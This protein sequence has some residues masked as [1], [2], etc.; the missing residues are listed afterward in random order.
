MCRSCFSPSFS[1]EVRS[2]ILR[3]NCVNPSTYHYTMQIEEVTTV[4][5]NASPFEIY[6]LATYHLLNPLLEIPSCLC[7]TCERE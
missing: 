4:S 7:L 1:S 6:P 2:H 5:L 3:Y